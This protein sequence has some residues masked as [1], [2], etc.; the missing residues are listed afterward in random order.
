VKTALNAEWVTQ[1]KSQGFVNPDGL[2]AVLRGLESATKLCA[3]Q[4]VFVTSLSHAEHLN[5]RHQATWC[6]GAC[7]ERI[8]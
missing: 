3:F 6:I 5:Q 1:A 7:A 4:F 8:A 2:S